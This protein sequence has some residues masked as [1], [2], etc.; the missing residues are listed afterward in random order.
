MNTRFAVQQNNK[1]FMD[2]HFKNLLRHKITINNLTTLSIALENAQRFFKKP[3]YITKNMQE[4]IHK[5]S[6]VVNIILLSMHFL[7]CHA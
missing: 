7:C 2:Q 6:F 4:N 5:K 1:Y 3:I